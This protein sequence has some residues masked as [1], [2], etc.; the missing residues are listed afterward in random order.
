MFTF[1]PKKGIPNNRGDYV[2]RVFQ[3]TNTSLSPKLFLKC[4]VLINKTLTWAL[5]IVAGLQLFGVSGARG[6][7]ARLRRGVALAPPPLLPAPAR[8]AALLPR[9]PLSPTT[10]N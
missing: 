7:G 1:A 4:V 2:A 8:R 3:M 10:V 5:N 9:A 6:A